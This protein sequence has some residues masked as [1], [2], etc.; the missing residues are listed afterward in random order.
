MHCTAMATRRASSVLSS[1][2]SSG[3]LLNR[4]SRTNAFLHGRCI[5]TGQPKKVNVQS[6]VEADSGAVGTK[7]YHLSNTALLVAA[8]L[9]LFLSPS[10]LTFPLDLF[11]GVAFPVHGHIG[12]NYI[13][14]DYVP[15]ASRPLARYVLLGATTVTVLGLLKLNLSGPG[16]TETYKSL[17]R[18]EKK[19]EA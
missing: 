16:L 1:L 13:I 15:R 4:T 8:P 5:S 11:L 7:F 10:P 6:L 18:A 12:I 2:P 9:A 14:S 19:E 17:W 3:A